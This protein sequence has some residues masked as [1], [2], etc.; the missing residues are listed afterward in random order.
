MGISLASLLLILV[1]GKLIKKRNMFGSSKIAVIKVGGVIISSDKIIKEIDKYRK[2][3]TVKAIVLRVN[4]PGGGVAPSQEIY[5]AVKKITRKKKIKI[6]VS[7]GSVAA[8]GGYYISCA[9]DR[10]VANPGTITGSL[11]VIMEFPN[12]KELLKKIGVENRNV[13]S[14]TYKDI[15][16][17]FREMK[18]EE[19]KL[20]KGMIDDVY[21]Q[22]VQAISESRG[23]PEDEVR[24]IAD[25]RIFSGRQAKAIGLVD[26]LGGFQVA[27]ETA[28][29]MTGLDL[30]KTV[31]LRKEESFR[32]SRFLSGL[33][34]F[35]E[36]MSGRLNQSLS[37][38]QYLWR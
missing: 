7:M 34:R 15:G 28:A 10:I 17:P 6:V 22:F 20:I 3:P 31:I 2:N 33:N 25:G 29:E 35:I 36:Q 32:I 24:K 23:M 14:G 9:A 27:L 5:E 18:S 19:K 38:V 21:E 26:K 37:P 30:D 11:G 1:L 4:S 16:S 13:K 12:I 8:S